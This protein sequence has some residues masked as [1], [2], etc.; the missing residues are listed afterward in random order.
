MKNI[1]WMLSIVFVLVTIVVAEEIPQASKGSQLLAQ[2]KVAT[3]EDLRRSVGQNEDTKQA[4]ENSAEWRAAYWEERAKKAEAGSL[5]TQAAPAQQQDGTSAE[6]PPRP[7]CPHPGWIWRQRGDKVWCWEAPETVSVDIRKLW[8]AN[9]GYKC[10][11]CGA[12]FPIHEPTCRKVFMK[13]PAEQKICDG[14]PMGYPYHT[15][16]CKFAPNVDDPV[17]PPVVVDRKVIVR[18]HVTEE[19]DRRSIVEPREERVVERAPSSTTVIVYRDRKVCPHPGWG[20]IET[21]GCW[22]APPHPGHYYH[23]QRGC[24]E[25]P[26]CPSG[27]NWEWNVGG[28]WQTRNTSGQHQKYGIGFG[29]QYNG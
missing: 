16:C 7:A 18:T 3:T 26:P 1:L 23:R 27:G 21:R 25:R 8:M 20:W 9:R 15:R 17:T 24:W 12:M 11:D 14:C 4:N 6:N 19:T 22:E 28:W 10:P 2:V 13:P 5:P 29:F